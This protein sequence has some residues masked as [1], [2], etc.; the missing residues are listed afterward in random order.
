MDERLEQI[1]VKRYPM[2]FRDY[3]GDM[4]KTCMAWGMSCGDGWFSLLDEMCHKITTMT[5]K[6]DTE[7][8]AHQVKEKFGSL[9]FYYGIEGP[10]TYFQKVNWK[11]RTFM[12]SRKWGVRYNKINN[13]RKKYYK[14]LN[15]K[16]SDIISDAEM[17]SYDICE[18]CGQPGE[19]KGGSWVTT[20]CDECDKKFDEGKRAWTDPDDFPS[21]YDK[22]FGGV[23]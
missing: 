3:R 19:R 1:L 23:D 8:I 14:N 16:L 10:M 17:K 20:S 18:T 13:F 15:E 12:C 4:T 9:R 5:K 22:L 6:T 21:I 11:I 2:M 7:V